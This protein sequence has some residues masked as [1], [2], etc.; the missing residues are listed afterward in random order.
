V[1]FGPFQRFWDNL[2]G[3]Y[4]IERRLGE[5]EHL[6]RGEPGNRPALK[7]RWFAVPHG[8]AVKQNDNLAPRF[9]RV[10]FSESGRLQ[11]RA[12]AP[13]S[14]LLSELPCKRL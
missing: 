5:G 9:G 4:R 2:R 7:R 10:G 14:N 11:L 8:Q 13:D 6:G 12:V 3:Q 1:G